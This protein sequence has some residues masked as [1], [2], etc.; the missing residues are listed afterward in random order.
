MVEHDLK[1]AGLTILC[2]GTDWCSHC[3]RAKR[4]E[5]IVKRAEKRHRSKRQR[6]EG[7]REEGGEDM[8]PKR[9]RLLKMNGSWT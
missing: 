2:E 8:M 7:K 1:E 6:A 3:R 4:M 5:R 9:H